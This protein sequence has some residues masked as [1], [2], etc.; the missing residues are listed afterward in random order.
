MPAI[1]ITGAQWGDEG[2]GRATDLLGSR[3]DYVVKFNG[4]NNAGHTVVVG[5]EKYALHLLPSG[6][7]T[8][9]VVPVIANGVVV[10]IEVLFHELEALSARGVDVSKLLVSANAHVITSYHRTLDKVTERFL[11]KRQI[12]TTG[13]G[14]GPAYADKINR[15]GIR[16]Q[17]LFDENILRQK[18]EGA[19]DQ[20]NHLLVKVY[21]R[22]AILVEQVLEDLLQ[23]TERLRPM[24]ADTSLILSQ[25]LDAGRTVLFEAG[26]ATMLD[27][28][29]GTYPFV[30]SSN[31]TSGGAA[32]GSGVA[33]NRIDRVIAVI[34]AYTTRVGAGPFP[35][36]L[37]DE[38]GEY[39]RRQGFEFGTTTGRPRR[40]GW[41]DA[42][43][44]RYSARING[45]TDFVLTK[46]DVL[47]GLETIPVCVAYD[48]D[49]VRHD[50]VPV[51]QSDF[52]H[53]KPIYEEFPGWQ[54]DISGCREFSDLPQTAQDYVRALE[55]MS[56]ARFSAIG[57]GPEREQVVVLHDLLD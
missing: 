22:R 53:A 9:G 37:F 15:V 50:E 44:A 47:S 56:G 30:T 20:K 51:S 25:A 5:D 3:V 26:Q 21:N 41:Y 54:E 32:T 38:W 36:E 46:L 52:H 17:D 43:I 29:H 10:D 4:G 1:V 42:P 16:I 14:I 18:V 27:V 33:P 28:D 55:A 57:V 35:T 48:V 31:A 40:C 39:L 2:K 34:K 6:I 45:V 7:L 24:V 49:G 11:G 12:G 8:P 23:Y 13:R 19:L